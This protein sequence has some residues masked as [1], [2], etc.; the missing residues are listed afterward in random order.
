MFDWLLSLFVIFCYIGE[1]YKWIK[2]GCSNYT[3]HGN[4]P[5]L[6]WEQSR[7][8]C[9]KTGLGDLV[10]I[11]SE[12]EWTFLKNTILN[13]TMADEYFIG[14]RKDGR[15]GQ[16]GWLSN[17]STSQTVLPW[18]KFE[19]SG[20]GN[21]AAMYKDYRGDYGKYNDLGCSTHAGRGYICEF[22]VD[23]C[24][25]EGKSCTFHIYRI[26]HRKCIRVVFAHE[27][28]SIRNRTSKRIE[29]VRFF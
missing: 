17:K 16:W 9:K 3:F 29:R 12:A 10:S 18:A 8:L 5:P 14:L 26:L 25:Q 19:P 28:A 2:S 13:L 27:L 1:T 11:E 24:K 7:K 22:P 6:V 15:S 4:S 20:D 23:R 21:C